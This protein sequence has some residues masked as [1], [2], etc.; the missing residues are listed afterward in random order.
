MRISMSHMPLFI[1]SHRGFWICE[2]RLEQSI[3]EALLVYPGGVA[4]Y[5]IN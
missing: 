4:E 2:V 3:G 1:K 5:G